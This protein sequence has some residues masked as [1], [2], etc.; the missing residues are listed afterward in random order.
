MSSRARAAISRCSRRHAPRGSRHV[1]SRAIAAVRV[2]VVQRQ[3]GVR[4]RL[5]EPR[6]LELLDP[7]R[8]S[9]G[10]IVG[11]SEPSA[12][13]SGGYPTACGCGRGARAPLTRRSLS[14]TTMSQPCTERRHAHGL[15]LTPLGEVG[16][17][18]SSGL[19]VPRRPLDDAH[20]LHLDCLV[21]DPVPGP[22]RHLPPA[23]H[24]RW[25]QGP[26]DRLGDPRAVP[27]RVRLHHHAEPSHGRARHEASRRR[28]RRSST[29]TSSRSRAA[30]GRPPR[31]RRP[32]RCSAR[33]RSHRP[34]STRSSARRSR[35]RNDLDGG[36]ATARR[37]HSNAL[38]AKAVAKPR[39]VT[40]PTHFPP[41][42]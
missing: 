4:L 15:S 20:L 9:L 25:K 16:R 7:V 12:P 42:A 27:G 18:G 13:V 37:P 40:T 29:S 35:R 6:R 31:S 8:V 34:S 24:R 14:R 22:D 3:H 23:R 26:L 11:A 10:D 36:P 19:P 28:R 39:V 30:A 33:A 41:F 38:I 5:L 17:S 21:H 32:T 2:H 1:E